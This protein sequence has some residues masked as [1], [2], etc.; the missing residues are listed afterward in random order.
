MK[1]E[2]TKLLDFLQASYNEYRKD[3]SPMM[4]E[5]IPGCDDAKNDFLESLWDVISQHFDDADE[6]A[7]AELSSD[8]DNID[9]PDSAKFALWPCN[10]CA[11][12]KPECDTD[13]QHFPCLVEHSKMKRF[14]FTI[15]LSGLGNCADGAW[16]DAVEGFG[17]D[18]GTPDVENTKVSEI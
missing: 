18:P 6:V 17:L 10:V 3:I 1:S 2:N 12:Q 8:I 7:E 15:T 5:D 16:Q 4:I 11:S 14:E 9:K 13:K